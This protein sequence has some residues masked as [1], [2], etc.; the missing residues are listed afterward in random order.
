MK[1]IV[2]SKQILIENV[3]RIG[4][5]M[6]SVFALSAVDCEFVYRSG[7]TKDYEIDMYCISGTNAALRRMSK[8]W[9]ARNQDNVSEWRDMSIR[10]LLCLSDK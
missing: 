9:L 3:K 2:N 6:V 5:V 10:G 7:Q 4:G 1:Y 8:D